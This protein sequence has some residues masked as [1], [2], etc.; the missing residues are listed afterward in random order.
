MKLDKEHVN[1]VRKP[2]RPKGRQF[3]ATIHVRLPRPVIDALR[4]VS[5][6]KNTN[7]SGVIR[8]AMINMFCQAV[9]TFVRTARD[10]TASPYNRL[11]A[12]KTIRAMSLAT[13]L[14]SPIGLKLARA[15]YLTEQHPPHQSHRP[16]T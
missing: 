6:G 11:S 9:P 5:G 12:I 4:S 8:A 15:N 16:M 14:L 13:L 2:G 1:T 3:D 10:E 7:L